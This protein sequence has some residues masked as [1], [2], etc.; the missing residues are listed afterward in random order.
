MSPVH[1]VWTEPSWKAQWKGEEDMAD[2][3]RAGRQ[4]QGMDRLGLHQLPDGSGEQGEMKK[5][6]TGCKIICGAI[7]T[8]GV[9]GWMMMMKM[10]F[11][12]CLSPLPPSFSS[13]S[14]YTS[15]VSDAWVFAACTVFVACIVCKLHTYFL[16]CKPL[17]CFAGRLCLC[18]TESWFNNLPVSI[19]FFYLFKK[20][21]S[22]YFL[23]LRERERE[24]E[25]DL[26]FAYYL[27][28]RESV[29]VWGNFSFICILITVLVFKQHPVWGFCFV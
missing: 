5:E 18:H 19:I 10:K 4:H 8:L 13:S 28:K 25:R 17:L 15:K 3:G 14:Q 9:K 20:K 21:L 27:C 12:I 7:T 11:W 6:K 2:T 29:C 24:R 26:E 16:K 1:Q 23:N 22:I